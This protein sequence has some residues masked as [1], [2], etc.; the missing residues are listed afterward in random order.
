MTDSGH[1][2][3][4]K[5]DRITK[6]NGFTS[7]L[8]HFPWLERFMNRLTLSRLLGPEF[9]PALPRTIP[10]TA[11]HVLVPLRR[12]FETVIAEIAPVRGCTSAGKFNR[13]MCGIKRETYWVLR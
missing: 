11:Q 4:R 12:V 10:M 5:D 9:L 3:K 13:R 8:I 7:T 6:R 2:E 1:E